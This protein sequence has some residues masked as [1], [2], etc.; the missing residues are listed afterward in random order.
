[1]YHPKLASVDGLENRGGYRGRYRYDKNSVKDR[2]RA[3]LAVCTK[4][5]VEFVLWQDELPSELFTLSKLT[6]LRIAF[7]NNARSF[8]PIAALSNLTDLSLQGCVGV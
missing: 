4:S 6:S 7:N 1:M 2:Y 5:D 8:G 3:G